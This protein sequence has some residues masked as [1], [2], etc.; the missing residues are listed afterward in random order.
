MNVC[1][2]VHECGMCPEA[3]ELEGNGEVRIPGEPG[4]A[5]AD[6]DAWAA[7]RSSE[8]PFLRVPANADRLVE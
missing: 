6:L 7:A 3:E 8:V 1:L 2:G 4:V 5:Y